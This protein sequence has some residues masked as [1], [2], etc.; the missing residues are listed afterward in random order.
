MGRDRWGQLWTLWT[1]LLSAVAALAVVIPS[2]YACGIG[3]V[4]RL[5]RSGGTLHRRRMAA[6]GNR[7]RPRDG[8]E[9]PAHGSGGA[10]GLICADQKPCLA[11]GLLSG[12]G[13][14]LRS[15]LRS[16]CAGVVPSVRSKQGTRRLA[17]EGAQCRQA[18]V[19]VR[20]PHSSDG[21]ARVRV[22]F[23]VSRRT[24]GQTDNQNEAPASSGKVKEVE[25][26]RK[27]A[28]SEPSTNR[29]LQ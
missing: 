12:E 29:N 16:H 28:R 19:L 4:G 17:A 21:E 14:R 3:T 22:V 27:E 10:A 23:V 11:G 15:P 8:L 7:P 26:G 1:V 6:G 13:D 5:G 2:H 24:G 20:Y 18:T 25:T 9:L